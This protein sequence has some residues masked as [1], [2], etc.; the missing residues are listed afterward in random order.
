[1]KIIYEDKDNSKSISLGFIPLNDADFYVM[2]N[3]KIKNICTALE[4]EFSF[5]PEVVEN[6]K[7]E[8][9]DS[10]MKTVDKVVKEFRNDHK[11]LSND[12]Y[13]LIFSDIKRWSFPAKEKFCALWHKYEQKMLMLNNSTITVTDKMI[14]ETVKFRN[15]ITHGKHRVL[16]NKIALTAH[17][18]SGLVYCCILERIG[19]DREKIIELCKEKILS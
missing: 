6:D 19:L 4:C 11:E 5:I 1:M 16:N 10:L 17:Y 7:N 12:V 3:E 2:T 15:D 9:I 13:S 18:L 14:E 8:T